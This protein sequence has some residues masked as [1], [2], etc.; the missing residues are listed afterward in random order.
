VSEHSLQAP[1]DPASIGPASRYIRESRDVLLAYD[2]EELA[3][4]R[5]SIILTA[6]W[7]DSDS[8]PPPRRAELREELALLRK[9]FGDKIDEIAMTF[10]VVSAIKAKEEVERTV[11]VPTETKVS[12]TPVHYEEELADNDFE[13]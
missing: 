11:I 4:L 6:R 9:H 5:F 7:A 13:V 1:L 12:G 2:I 3:V 10:G 8:E